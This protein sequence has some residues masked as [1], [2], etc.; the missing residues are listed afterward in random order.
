VKKRVR[1]WYFQKLV[2]TLSTSEI[3]F[4]Q[5]PRVGKKIVQGYCQFQPRHKKEWLIVIR[6]RPS[7]VNE[8]YVLIH[9][10]LHAIFPDWTER[11]CWG[12]PVDLV[13]RQ[14]LF[15]FSTNQHKEL[16]KFLPRR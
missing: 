15:D 12:E 3:R 1:D 7:Y 16:L 5:T 13:A 10:G 6:N 8:L 14:L 4:E 2:D 11:D 9:E